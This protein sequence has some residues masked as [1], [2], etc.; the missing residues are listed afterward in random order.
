MIGATGLALWAV[1]WA[2]DA[3][4]VVARVGETA[5]LRALRDAPGAPAIPEEAYRAA[6]AGEIRTGLQAVEGHAAK[7]AW[8]VAV[9]DQGIGSLWSALNDDAGRVAH[10]RLSASELVAGSACADRRAVLQ[11]LPV[12]LISDRWW[13]SHLQVNRRLMEA[14]G[15]GVRELSW[16][17]SVDP[18]EVRSASGQALIAEGTPLAFTKGGWLL[19]ALDPGHTLVEYYVWT[20]PGGRVPAGVAS[21]FAAGGITETIAGL[22][23]QAR[24]GAACPAM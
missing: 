4:Q 6:A 10:T 11:F 9:V 21:S 14:S 1:A 20:D 13:I 19:V 24:A 22:G 8:G 23:A 7:K 2:V 3:E 12:P 17:S 18:A 16:R 15:G 5:E